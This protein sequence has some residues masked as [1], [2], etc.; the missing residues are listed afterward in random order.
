MGEMGVHVPKARHEE[1]TTGVNDFRIAGDGR[2]LGS[3][4]LD[5]SLLDDDGLARQDA[6]STDIN[7][8]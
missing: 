2:S 8:G 6:P 5:T 1:L 3:A 4:G 7:V